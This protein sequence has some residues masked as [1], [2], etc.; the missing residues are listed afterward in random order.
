MVQSPVYL[1][2]T[3]VDVRLSR[4]SVGAVGLGRHEIEEMLVSAW[5]ERDP[6]KSHS[7]HFVVCER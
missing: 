5:V 7:D 2:K 1:S 6:V 4:R 3:Q